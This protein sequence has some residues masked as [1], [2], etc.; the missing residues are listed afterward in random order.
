MKTKYSLTET[1]LYSMVILAFVSVGLVGYFWIIYEYE[2]FQKEKI[3]LK[4]EYFAA[5]KHLIK[6]E[7]E[8]VVDY[9][10]FKKS[11]AAERLRR[12][13]NKG[14]NENQQYTDDLMTQVMTS[15][16]A[17]GLKM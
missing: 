15:G 11:Q 9:I 7:T 17:G 3:T 14:V 16:I 13:R 2:R 5:Q 12:L 10:A 6:N 8:K 4:E 1:F